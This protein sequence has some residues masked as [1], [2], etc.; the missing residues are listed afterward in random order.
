MPDQ[1][2]Q[3]AAGVD[4]RARQTRIPTGHMFRRQGAR[5][6]VWYA[7]YRLPDGRQ[8]QRRIGSA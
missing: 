7:T 1:R 4:M 6:D 5:G 3:G 8:M 2:N